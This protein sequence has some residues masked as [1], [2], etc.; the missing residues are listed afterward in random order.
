MNTKFDLTQGP[1][2][3]KLVTMAMPIMATSFM[4]MAFNLADMFWL[5]RISPAAVAAAGTAGL[6]F[7]CLW[8]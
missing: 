6:F 5:G 8:H 7:G 2:L 3:K 4:Q 1:I